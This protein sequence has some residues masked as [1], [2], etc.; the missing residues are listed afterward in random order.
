MCNFQEI[1][2]LFVRFDTDGSGT[3]DFEE[4]L[5]KLRVSEAEG[6]REREREKEKEREVLNYMYI[7]T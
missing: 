7:D 6:G 3:I 5:E 1:K 2:E 4:F